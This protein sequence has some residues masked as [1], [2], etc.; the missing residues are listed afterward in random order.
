MADESILLEQIE[1]ILSDEPDLVE[2]AR[3]ALSNDTPTWL[4][5]V[6]RKWYTIPLL[7][8]W[9]RRASS[10]DGWPETRYTKKRASV[11]QLER[12]RKVLA[13]LE[14]AE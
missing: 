2:Q 5:E 9:I 14:Q 3:A 1:T 6:Y 13:V 8:E 11:G 12:W 10:G 7:R 4:V